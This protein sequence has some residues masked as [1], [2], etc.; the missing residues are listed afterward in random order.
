[1]LQL[2]IFGGFLVNKGFRLHRCAATQASASEEDPKASLVL[3]D[4]NI[5]CNKTLLLVYSK[6]SIF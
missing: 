4:Y 6:K 1:M 3:D 5:T 2:K